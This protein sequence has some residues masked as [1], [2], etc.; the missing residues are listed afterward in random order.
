MSSWEAA[1]LWGNGLGTTGVAALRTQPERAFVTESQV[2]KALTELG[3]LGLLA[4]AFL[5]FQ[6]ARIAIKTYRKA[7]ADGTSRILLLGIMTS[8]LIIFIEGF[9]YQNLEV[10][11]VN[12]Y[13]WTLTGM[14]AFLAGNINHEISSRH[15]HRELESR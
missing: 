10:K 8:L 4:L 2:L 13:F 14:L 7:N 5:W 6:I 15:H 11:Q 3:V 9:V 12:A 1:P